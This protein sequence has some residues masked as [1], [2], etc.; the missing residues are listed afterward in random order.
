M[1]QINYLEKLA[2]I[3]DAKAIR[4]DRKEKIKGLVKEIFSENLGKEPPLMD[5]PKLILP[6]Q[7]AM[8]T[9]EVI[10]FDVLSQLSQIPGQLCTLEQDKFHASNQE[11]SKYLKVPIIDS[12]NNGNSNMRY[13]KLHK[14]MKELNGTPLAD[15]NVDLNNEETIPLPKYHRARTRQLLPNMQIEDLSKYF[16]DPNLKANATN[17][18]LTHLLLSGGQNI[19][20]EN[21]DDPKEKKFRENIVLPA[22]EKANELLSNMGMELAIIKLPDM[23]K[24]HYYQPANEEVYSDMRRKLEHE[25]SHKFN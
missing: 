22:Y 21:F 15:I 23:G 8:P 4:E 16:I 20:V 25:L 24:S 6:R 19:L 2:N 11:K 18:Y 1:T 3:K 17:Y 12:I 7:V 9:S 13:L 5:S 14:N 10:A